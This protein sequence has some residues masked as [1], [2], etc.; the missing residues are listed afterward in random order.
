MKREDIQKAE[1]EL[2]KIRQ[3]LRDEP[4]VSSISPGEDLV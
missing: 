3:S 2:N 4:I 1:K